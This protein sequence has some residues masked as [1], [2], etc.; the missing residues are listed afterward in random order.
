MENVTTSVEISCL[1]N[2]NQMTVALHDMYFSGKYEGLL[3][4]LSTVEKYFLK[5]TFQKN[6]PFVYSGNFFL[7]Q[8]IL[9]FHSL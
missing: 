8:C 5:I 6:S 2:A 3:A 4:Y 7:T 9:V 1:L